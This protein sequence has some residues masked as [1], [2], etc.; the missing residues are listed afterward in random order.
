MLQ[1]SVSLSPVSWLMSLAPIVSVELCSKCQYYW[2]TLINQIPVL[3]L[4]CGKEQ[5]FWVFYG[6]NTNS[7]YPVGV[8]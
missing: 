5:N 6:P 3:G 7:K 8:W 1:S 4:N 2:L